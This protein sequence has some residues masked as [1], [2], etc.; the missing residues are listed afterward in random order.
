MLLD[1]D[2]LSQ[3]AQAQIRLKLSKQIDRLPEPYKA[4]MRS[5]CHKYETNMSELKAKMEALSVSV[6]GMKQP[7]LSQDDQKA[8][9]GK[10]EDLIKSTLEKCLRM[11]QQLKR[12][13]NRAVPEKDPE[14]LR[15]WLFDHF[16]SPY[17]TPADKEELARQSGYTPKQVSNWFINARVRL[18]RPMILQAQCEKEQKTKVKEAKKERT[19]KVTRSVGG[20]GVRL[21]SRAPF[22]PLPSFRPRADPHTRLPSLRS[23]WRGRR[24][25]SAAA[26]ARSLCEGK[27]SRAPPPPCARCYSFL[28]RS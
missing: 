26:G 9:V 12:N 14:V 13:T 17:P 5:I 21:H 18:W 4:K 25:R 1:S 7:F 2:P 6:D 28:L 16:E 24:E 11:L 20:S 22:P 23:G 27:D 15:R 10:S 19:K 3:T 8:W